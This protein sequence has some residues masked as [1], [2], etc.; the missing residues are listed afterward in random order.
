MFSKARFP[1]KPISILGVFVLAAAGAFL[2]A[3]FSTIIQGLRARQAGRE[4]PG[5]A[6]HRPRN[7]CLS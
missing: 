5:D 7:P 1:R 6:R 4:K 2:R 3:R